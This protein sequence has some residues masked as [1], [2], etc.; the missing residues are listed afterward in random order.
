MKFKTIDATIIDF[1]IFNI[2]WLQLVGLKVVIFAVKLI[3]L[4]LMT[5]ILL[6]SK[7]L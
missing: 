6:S 1:K 4:L 3:I 7:C 5:G 2:H